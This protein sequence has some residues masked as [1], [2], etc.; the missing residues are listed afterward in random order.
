[1]VRPNTKLKRSEV[2]AEAVTNKVKEY[3]YGY[4]SQYK[5]GVHMGSI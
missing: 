3:K 1:M 5:Y 2:S 4:Y